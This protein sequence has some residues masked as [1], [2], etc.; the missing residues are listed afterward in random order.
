MTITMTGRLSECLLLA[1][2]TPANNV[3]HLL[4]KGLELVTRGDFAFWNLVVCRVERM[5]PT[6]FPGWC[7]VS[8]VHVAYRLYVRAPLA[9]GEILDGL[10]FV[11]SDADDALLSWAGNLVSDFK[12][13]PAKIHLESSAQNC[14]LRVTS[15]GGGDALLKISFDANQVLSKDSCF[16]TYAE[17]SHFLKYRPIGLSSDASGKQL[18]LAEVFRNE[19]DWRETPIGMIE[20]KWGFLERLGQNEIQLE[21]GTRVAPIHYRWRLGRRAQ[22]AQS[23]SQNNFRQRVC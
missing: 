1:Y 18:K 3:R 12:F 20:A 8:Y 4:P 16:P 14:G 9:N 21:L 2:R 15:G 5:R 7:G 19:K 17:A 23:S 10:Y 11:R 13:H 6:G 22:L